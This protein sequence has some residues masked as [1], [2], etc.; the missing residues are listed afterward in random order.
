MMQQEKQNIN[1]Q[2]IVYAFLFTWFA[3]AMSLVL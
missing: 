2:L 3:L 1:H